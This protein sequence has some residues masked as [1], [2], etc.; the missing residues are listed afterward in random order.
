M[1]K[2]ILI[3]E[4]DLE[5]LNLCKLILSK[6]DR[7]IETLS[8]C[9]HI[10]SDIR[11][12]KPSVILMDLWIPEIGGERAVTLMKENAETSDIPVI[13]FSANDEIEAICEKVDANGFLRKPFDIAALKEIIDDNIL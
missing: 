5:I 6:P 12:F 8:R 9:E 1:K 3:Y 13:L 4:D 7:R 2:C 10:V 11:K